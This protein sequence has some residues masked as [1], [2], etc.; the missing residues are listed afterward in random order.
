MKDRHAISNLAWKD[1]VGHTHN[2]CKNDYSM[3]I[4]ERSNQNN[5]NFFGVFH[6]DNFLLEAAWW[7]MTLHI[8]NVNCLHIEL[9]PIKANKH[10]LYTP[11]VLYIRVCTVDYLTNCDASTQTKMDLFS[12]QHYLSATDR[13]M[14]ASVL[15][16]VSPE[17]LGSVISN[18]A[19]ATW[20]ISTERWGKEQLL[21]S[22]KWEYYYCQ[23]PQE[24]R[25]HK[26]TGKI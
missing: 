3:H 5:P 13:T 10:A 22:K 4:W 15:G 7:K 26:Y 18:K 12:S 8:K 17:N 9:S 14:P 23:F 20:N 11:F 24:A 2:I 16:S 21:L 25:V 1:M 6:F 19:S